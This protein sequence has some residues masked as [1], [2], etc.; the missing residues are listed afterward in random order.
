VI[1][2]VAVGVV[3]VAVLAWLGVMER[4]TR[5]EASGLAAARQLQ[6]PGNLER[7]DADLRAARL[8]NADTTPDLARAVVYQAA[9]RP[10]QAAA[11]VEDILRREPE[12]LRAWGLLLAIARDRDPAAARRALAARRRLD[13]VNA[14]TRR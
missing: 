8:L 1:A 6:V 12:N 4:N 10:E 2:R 7:A 14:V 5:L 9:Q 3:A 11:L 13:P